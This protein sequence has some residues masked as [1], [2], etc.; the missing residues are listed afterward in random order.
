MSNSVAK[1]KLISHW[2]HKV[3][4]NLEAAEMLF[5]LS[6]P[7][8]NYN[9]PITVRWWYTLNKNT[10]RTF[11]MQN[12]RRIVNLHF[13][14]WTIFLYCGCWHCL[15][16]YYVH[17]WACLFFYEGEI[18]C[19]CVCF[20]FHCSTLWANMTVIESEQLQT[21]KSSAKTS[22]TVDRKNQIGFIFFARKTN[23]SESKKKLAVTRSGWFRIV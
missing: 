4:S 9:N 18:M 7:I 14:S 6:N 1:L 13:C 15:Y 2:W 19:A 5:F 16:Y 23:A 20:F 17:C 11:S 3:A 12:N 21:G 8:A 10:M 22:K